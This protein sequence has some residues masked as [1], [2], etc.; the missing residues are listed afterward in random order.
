MQGYSNPFRLDRN[1][2]GGG[3]LL[4]VREDIPAKPISNISF[5]K[6]IVAMFV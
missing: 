4:Y 1:S 3:I 2:Y 6:D 5:D